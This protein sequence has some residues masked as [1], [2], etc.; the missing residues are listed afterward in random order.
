M[1]SS[2]SP[3][4]AAALHRLT[5]LYDAARYGDWSG[6]DAEHARAEADAAVVVGLLDAAPE[7]PAP[8]AV[9]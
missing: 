9:N 5:A 7:P 4:S 2:A 8:D 3:G 1:I 6:T